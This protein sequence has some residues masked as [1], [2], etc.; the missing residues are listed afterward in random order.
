MQIL[1]N[2]GNDNS[3]GISKINQKYCVLA[4]ASIFIF[5]LKSTVVAWTKFNCSKVNWRHLLIKWDIAGFPETCSCFG[6]LSNWKTIVYFWKQI[7][8]FIA[9]YLFHRFYAR[10]NKKGGNFNRPYYYETLF[11]P[12]AKKRNITRVMS[13]ENNESQLKGRAGLGQLFQQQSVRG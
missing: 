5:T 9:L 3:S 11:F 8:N 12:M 1:R 13:T 4:Y 2:N 7:F 6:A 10:G